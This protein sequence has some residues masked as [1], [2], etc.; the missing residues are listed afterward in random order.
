MVQNKILKFLDDGLGAHYGNETICPYWANKLYKDMS[1]P[2]N[3]RQFVV[4]LLVWNTF[5]P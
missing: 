1:R 5:N 2:P 4:M 3:L